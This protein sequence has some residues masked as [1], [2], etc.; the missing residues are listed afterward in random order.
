MAGGSGNEG[1]SLE[2][3]FYQKEMEL[4]KLVFTQQ[5]THAVIY[6]WVK[7]RE[8]VSKSIPTRIRRILTARAGNKKHHMDRRMHRAEPERPDR[9]LHQCILDHFHDCCE[10]GLPRQMCITQ[11]VFVGACRID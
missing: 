11:G 10:F 6:A 2:D 4:S 1:K 9:K 5:F 8:Q 7:L 3:M